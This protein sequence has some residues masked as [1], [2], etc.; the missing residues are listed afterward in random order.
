MRRQRIGVIG[1]GKIATDQHLPT[2]A[3]SDAFELAAVADPVADLSGFSVPA[4]RDAAALLVLPDLDAVAICTPPGA[5]TALALAALAAGRHV[6]LEKPPA[7]GVTALAAV[8]AAARRHGRVLFTAWHSQFN[9]AVAEARRRLAGAAVARIEVTWCEDVRRW[10]PGQAWIWR[11]GGFGVFDPGVNALSI[12]THVLPEPLA[13]LG[14]ELLVPTGAEAPIA[15]TVA[16]GVGG[17]DD[18][19]RMVLDWRGDVP[20]RR[21]IAITLADGTRLDLTASGGRLAV[22]GAIVVDGPRTE[23]PMLY[24]RFA[25]LLRDGTSDVDAAPLALAADTL[26]IGRRTTIGAWQ[27]SG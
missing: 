9:A 27:D 10:H 17:R 21:E 20:E 18:G 24:R 22:D 12:L 1:L 6:L 4:F 11:A 8:E 26:Q 23:Y 2:I 7:I 15:A 19:S 14:A 13:V 5:R 3:A 16:L 25:E